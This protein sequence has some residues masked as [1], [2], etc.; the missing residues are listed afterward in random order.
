M[1]DTLAP[2]IQVIVHGVSGTPPAAVLGI[3]DPQPLPG[4]NSNAA[5]FGL[6]PDDPRSVPDRTTLAFSWSKMTSGSPRQALWL[7]LLPF[8]LL[9]IARFMT[10]TSHADEDGA[11]R[12]STDAILRVMGLALTLLL[13]AAVCLVSVDMLAW[14]GL[15]VPGD[16]GVRL[17]VAVLVPVALIALISLLGRS[18]YLADDP[19]SSQS[20]G[21]ASGNDDAVDAPVFWHDQF[22]VM[23]LRVLHTIAAIAL[24]TFLVAYSTAEARFVTMPAWTSTALYAIAAASGLTVVLS[25]IFVTV[26]GYPWQRHSPVSVGTSR[27]MAV[28]GALRWWRYLSYALLAAS[29]AIAA[30]RGWALPAGTPGVLHGFGNTFNVLYGVLAVGLIALL[31]ATWRMRRKVHDET[32]PLPF[33][34]IWH[35]YA[36]PIIA[37]TGVLFGTAYTGGL[38]YVVAYPLH[39]FSHQP[40]ALPRA[41]SSTVLAWGFALFASVALALITVIRARI[42]YRWTAQQATLD[43]IAVQYPD[44]ADGDTI[45]ASMRQKVAKAWWIATL[46]YRAPQ[47]FVWL[48][49]LGTLVGI[50]QTSVAVS[51][52]IQRLSHAVPTPA[53]FSWIGVA[54]AVFV[55]AIA[56]T[57]FALG[58]VETTSLGWRRGI[59]IIWDLLAFWPRRAHPI[60]PEPYGGNAVVTLADWTTAQRQQNADMIVL[61]GHSQG[62][63]IVLATTRYLV[64]ND[65]ASIARLCMMTYGSQL[66]WAYPRMFP[67]YVGIDEI[68]D[69]QL[70]VNGS[71][72]NLHRWTDQLGAPVLAFPDVAVKHG[73]SAR[74]IAGT[75]VTINGTPAAETAFETARRYGDGEFGMLDPATVTGGRGVI[76][77]HCDFSDPSFDDITTLLVNHRVG[78]TAPAPEQPA[79]ALE[80][81]APVSVNRPT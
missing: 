29:V 64:H 76:H 14:Q 62:S 47:V 59:G 54:G 50:Y 55:V 1:A 24:V 28:P 23:I 71:W 36:T 58:L 18:S 6:G 20:S 66:Q 44:T 48:A 25:A 26:S 39:E 17:I 60:A 16:Y 19:R 38:A 52:G 75:W 9:N 30:V 78:S 37:A 63:L 53:P 77:G 79:P 43:A 5:F 65:P 46:K 32:T 67:A 3:S 61:T 8:G 27:A 33:R 72:F 73:Y 81:P 15:R 11:G 51:N 13:I 42:G 10:P 40:I 57:L 35:G 68:R 22:P 69:T 80:Q 34:P 45:N 7:L 74:N 12:R 2:S 31:T 41:V 56:V 21:D 4:G 70:D 49:V